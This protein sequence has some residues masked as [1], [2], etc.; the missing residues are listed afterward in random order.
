MEWRRFLKASALAAIPGVF[1]Q[2]QPDAV[3]SRQ[4]VVKT[5]GEEGEMKYRNR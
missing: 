1:A 3:G 5:Q 4:P 2:G